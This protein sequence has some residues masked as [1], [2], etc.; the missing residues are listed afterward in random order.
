MPALAETPPCPR[1]AAAFRRRLA[2]NPAADAAPVLQDEHEREDRHH[3]PDDLQHQ[4]VEAARNAEPPG[5][6]CDRIT[7]HGP[8]GEPPKPDQQVV[9]RFLVGR[10][11]ARRTQRR[12]QNAL[13]DRE[14][15]PCR[16]RRLHQHR[17]GETRHR[18]GRHA[19]RQGDQ[20]GA[21][22][23]DDWRDLAKNGGP[24]PQRLHAAPFEIG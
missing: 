22:K 15:Q 5:G 11:E 16:D 21:R 8:I 24:G 19:H 14:D 18:E 3:Q 12:H 1:P 10:N 20:R 9:A 6:G 23:D 13:A 7:E 2:G 17:Q 4:G